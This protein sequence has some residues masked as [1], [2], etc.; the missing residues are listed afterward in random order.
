[1]G[2]APENKMPVLPYVRLPVTVLEDSLLL[3]R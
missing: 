2:T 3:L 1:M